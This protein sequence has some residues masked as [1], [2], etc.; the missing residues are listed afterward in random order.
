MEPVYRVVIRLDP[1]RVRLV[2][3]APSGDELVRASLPQPV[4]F[5]SGNPAK[6]LL[7]SLAIWLDTRL[8]VVLSA[9]VPA[10]GFLLEL[11]DEGGTG[12]RTVLYD[13][14]VAPPGRR[15]RP[16]RLRGVGDF[17]DVHQ[18]RLDDCLTGGRR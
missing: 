5:W 16:V 6:A 17:Q 2:L 18:L 4:T 9:D 11:T 1:N 14:A 13:V 8:R 3:T 15:R 7:E 12:L 10:D